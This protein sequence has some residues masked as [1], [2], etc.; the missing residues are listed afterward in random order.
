MRKLAV[1]GLAAGWLVTGD[2]LIG[3]SLMTLAVGW[4]LLPTYEGPPVLPLA[5]T[6]QWVSVTI[7]FFYVTL[8]GR[9]LDA[10][11]H[12]DYRTMVMI[13][14]GCV[15]SMAAGLWLG[16][17]LIDRQAPPKGL[18]PAHALTFK[19]LM[20]VYALGTTFLLPVLLFARDYPGLLQGL[21]ALTYLRLGLLYLIFRRL[22]GQGR[23]YQ[24][25]GLLAVEIVLGISGFFA[26]FRE[27]LIMAALAYLEFFD[28]RKVTQWIALGC[29]G[30]AM[31]VLGI[32]WLNIRI[33]YRQR[34]QN[35]EKFATDRS[36]RID[37]LKESVSVWASQST[38]EFWNDADAFADRMWTIYYPA[39][40][41]ERVPSVLPHTN[42]DLM[43]QSMEFAFLPRLFF[44]D[45]PDVISDSQMVRKYSGIAV[46]G[47]ESN[48]DIAFGYAAESYI[49]F[50]VP[51]MFVPMLLWATF[52]GVA[53]AL[54]LREYRHRD[55]ATSVATVICWLA[56]YLFERSWTKTVGLSGTLLI[57]AGGLSYLLDRLWFEKT[58]A[59]Y[60]AA[61]IGVEDAPA[62]SALPFEPHVK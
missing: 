52:M 46:A 6:M 29:L 37:A 24:V 20:L 57:Y 36:A 62:L 19:T 59:A 55:I 42:G 16:R 10:S 39:L 60:E 32:A 47:D 41:V 33:D 15:L 61:G 35:D 48:T 7:G 26:G 3:A 45:K 51:L 14:L 5:F 12:S 43:L 4:M 30:L 31:C 27:P 2:W 54:I 44:P 49:D 25:M 9:A 17:W 11:I 18:R 1:A 40:A 28:R 34:F 21:I 13:G 38:A 8:T 53:Y 56:L 23:T 22:V 58:R 50:G